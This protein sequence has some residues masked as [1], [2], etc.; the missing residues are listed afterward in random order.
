M[1]EYEPRRPS[2][3][4]AF[5]ILL[6]LMGA[7]LIIGGV[8][9]IGAWV[10]MTGKGIFTIEKDMLN[11]LYTNAARVMQA[12]SVFFMFFLPA[13]VTARI[14]NRS[15]FT[16]LGYREGF[17]A[18]QFIL[19][20]VMLAACLPLVGALAEINQAIPLSARLEAM[21]KKMEDNYT[22]EATALATMRSFSEYIFS[23]IVIALLPAVFEETFFRG[24][25]QQL[26]AGWFKKPMAAI[27]VTSIVFSAMHFSWYGFLTRFALGMVLGL[28]FY[29]SRSIWLNMVLHFL[30]NGLAVTYMYYLSAHNKPVKDA[31]DENAP[32]WMGLPALL[33][34][35]LLFRYFRQVSLQR[36]NDRPPPMDGPAFESTLV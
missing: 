28:I 9:G 29:Y 7:G 4:A 13:V 15:P 5:F 3:A 36:N 33:V 24:G 30:N 32:I 6:G 20:V 11:P 25:M 26:L 1:M 14:M 2:P 34:L 23:L 17:N 19:V 10:A 18:R 16:W 35:V 21:V 22:Q 8:A 12:V 31:L 27:V